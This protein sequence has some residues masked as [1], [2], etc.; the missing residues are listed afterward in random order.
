MKNLKKFNENSEKTFQVPA[1]FNILIQDIGPNPTASDIISCWNDCIE[2]NPIMYYHEGSNKFILEDG[3]STPEDVF[4]CLNDYLMGDDVYEATTDKAKRTAIS[5]FPHIAKEDAEKREKR[6]RRSQKED[7][8]GM[9]PRDD[10]RYDDSESEGGW[11]D[12]MGEPSWLGEGRT[13]KA[14]KEKDSD[15]KLE[16]FRKTIGDFLKAK[17]CKTKKVGDDFE[18]HFNDEHVAQVIFRKDYVGVKKEGNKFPKEFN[19]NELG[20]IKSELTSIIKS[21]KIVKEM[22]H[23]KKFNESNLRIQS[24]VPRPESAVNRLSDEELL[25]QKEEF[26]SKKQR[27][28]DP[29]FLQEVSDRLYGPDSDGYIEALKELNKN[30]RPRLGRTGHDI[31]TPS[32][33]I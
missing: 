31:F 7:P 16:Q 28:V 33:N 26:F 22:K 10:E 13:E 11:Q 8:D 3:E 25:K 24:T 5:N 32:P 14:S 27:G 19:Y 12:G 9:Y 23:I 17:D 18:V 15:V 30:F 29:Y 21:G 2:D 20:K 1:E 4:I 6:I